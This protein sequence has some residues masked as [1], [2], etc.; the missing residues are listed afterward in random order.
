MLVASSSLPLK[1]RL[2]QFFS[3]CAIYRHKK[4]L[5]MKK[6]LNFLTIV[7]TLRRGMVHM[8]FDPRSFRMRI[9]THG[10]NFW[11]VHTSN[12]LI[13]TITSHLPLCVCM[14]KLSTIR[15][16]R[17]F[18]TYVAHV[19]I[20]YHNKYKRFSHLCG[21]I[22]AAHL[23]ITH[24]DDF[25]RISTIFLYI[26]TH[27]SPNCTLEWFGINWIHLKN[28]K[29]N[30]NSVIALIVN[31]FALLCYSTGVLGPTLQPISIINFEIESKHERCD[32]WRIQWSS[33]W[34]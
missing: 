14:W 34:T 7:C 2:T 18:P 6:K 12:F 24:D 15:T 32:T 11:W 4:A 9:I 33:L 8:I 21:A 17:D 5:L 28:R 27:R 25:E 22:S 10:V 3:S 16:I 30:I 13:C 20:K 23:M 29:E 31:I 19:K 26:H 1:I